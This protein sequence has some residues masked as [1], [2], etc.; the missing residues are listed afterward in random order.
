M[1]GTSV[2][3]ERGKCAETKKCGSKQILVMMEII[4]GNLLLI[5]DVVSVLHSSEGIQPDFQT[6]PL[7]DYHYLHT[8]QDRWML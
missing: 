3:V 1:R 2:G 4:H 8:V 6:N 5:V 7:F